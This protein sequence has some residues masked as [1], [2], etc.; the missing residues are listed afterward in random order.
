ML[1]RIVWSIRLALAE[2][3]NEWLFTAGVSFAV[4]SILTTTSLLWGTKSGMI[5]GMRERLLEDP[6]NRELISQ[7][8]KAMPLG[9][10]REI[11]KHPSSAFLIPSVRRISLYGEAISRDDPSKTIETA[12]LPTAEGDPLGGGVKFNVRQPQIPVPCMVTALAAEDLGVAA[13]DSIIL[14]ISRRE[15]GKSVLVNVEANVVRTLSHGDSGVRAIFLPL[16]V[17]E[18][19]EDYKEGQSVGMFGWKPFGTAP[20]ELYDSVDLKFARPLPL[21]AAERIAGI[22]ESRFKLKSEVVQGGTFLRLGPATDGVPLDVVLQL[23][24]LTKE[25]SPQAR[26]TVSARASE[27]GE[28]VELRTTPDTWL[29]VE[30]LASGGRSL[31]TNLN[32]P[33]RWLEFTTPDGALSSVGLVVDRSSSGSM[34]LTPAQAGLVGAAERKPVEINQSTADFRPVRTEFPGFRLY[35]RQLEDVAQL[36]HYCQERGIEVKTQ[37]DRINSVITL[38]EALGRFLTFIITAGGVGGLGALASSIHLS[39]QRSR[40]QFAVMQILGIPRRYVLLSVVV[41]SVAIVIAGTLVS[42]VLFRM[43]SSLLS[44]ILDVEASS[45]DKVCT[46]ELVQWMWLLLVGLATAIL[47]TLLSVTGM[48]F[49]DPAVI[50]RSE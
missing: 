11:A 38:D 39:V 18:R 30:E 10:L 41:Q 34:E 2:L 49:S 9:L 28:V 8:N 16:P 45:P 23:G 14:R 13:G 43:G 20:L 22:C 29:P 46:L 17:I 25:W 48:R 31:S 32:G 44:A 15:G 33:L 7:E 3:R 35:A 4:C 42:F 36:R 24:E 26:V 5:A 6:V 50:A 1:Q 19:V 12:F 27:G 40:R 47:A 37:E 21:D